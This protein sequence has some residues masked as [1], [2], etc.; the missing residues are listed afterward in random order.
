MNPSGNIKLANNLLNALNGLCLNNYFGKES[1]EG[2]GPNDL[3]NKSHDEVRDSINSDNGVGLSDYN[4]PFSTRHND[5][6]IQNTPPIACSPPT[7]SMN[8]RLQVWEC[9]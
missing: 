2:H 6:C 4:T 7:P 3:V 8:V 5:K 9:K 1:L